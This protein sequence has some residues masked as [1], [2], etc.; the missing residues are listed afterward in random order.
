MNK[1]IDSSITKFHELN[2]DNQI[3]N[4]EQTLS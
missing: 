2:M 1:K 4:K 3:L